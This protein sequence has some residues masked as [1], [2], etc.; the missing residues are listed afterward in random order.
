MFKFKCLILFNFLAGCVSLS[1][2]AP[3]PPPASLKWSFM[4]PNNRVIRSIFFVD[5]CGNTNQHILT[6]DDK[7]LF[8]VTSTQSNSSSYLNNSNVVLHAL[9]S[10]KGMEKWNYSMIQ[11]Q[12]NLQKDKNYFPRSKRST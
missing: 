12:N 7:T 2:I 4:P 9:D 10:E 6:P 1:T 8:T 11:I 3:P 5:K